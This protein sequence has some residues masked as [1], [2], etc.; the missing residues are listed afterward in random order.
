MR[1]GSKKYDSVGG[2]LPNTEM[3]VVNPETQFSQVALQTGEIYVRGPQVR[4]RQI[5]LFLLP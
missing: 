1:R 2:P 5:L 3:K 4:E